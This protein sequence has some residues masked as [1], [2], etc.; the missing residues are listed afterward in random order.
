MNYRFILIV[1][2]IPL[3][4]ILSACTVIRPRSLSKDIIC[5]PPPTQ[6]CFPKRF[7]GPI[8]DTSSIGKER[9]M[10]IRPVEGLN[11][12]VIDEWNISFLSDSTSWNTA[13]AGGSQILRALRFMNESTISEISTLDMEEGGSFGFVS[14]V[15]RKLLPPVYRPEHIQEMHKL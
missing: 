9:F 15:Q 5:P 1:L 6:D 14:G 10:R 3:L 4:A 7:A 2:V 12:P 8:L 13:S 11:T